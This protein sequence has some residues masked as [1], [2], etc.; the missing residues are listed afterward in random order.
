MKCSLPKDMIK[1]I[2]GHHKGRKFYFNA[3]TDKWDM[4]EKVNSFH[5]Q[6]IKSYL[7]PN[8][9]EPPS[10]AWISVDY[11]DYKSYSTLLSKYQYT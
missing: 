6:E 10:H 11:I 2:I 9:K 4:F 5:I 3:V 1:L 7:N 8:Y